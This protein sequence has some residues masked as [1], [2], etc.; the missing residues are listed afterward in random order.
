MAV[1]V[2]DNLITTLFTRKLYLGD[3]FFG[4]QRFDIAVDS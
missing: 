2:P 1:P 4:K 3:F